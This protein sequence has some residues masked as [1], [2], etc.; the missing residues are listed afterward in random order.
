MRRC[1]DAGE[2]PPARVPARSS[3]VLQT[4]S[5]S[6]VSLTCLTPCGT[7]GQSL[8]RKRGRSGETSR[9]PSGVWR[10][11]TVETSSRSAFSCS[12]GSGQFV[13]GAVGEP[14]G[15]WGLVPS[16]RKTPLVPSSKRASPGA[17]ESDR[18]WVR[19]EAGPGKGAGTT[20]NSMWT[21]LR[22]WA[23]VRVWRPRVAMCLA[24]RSGCPR[25]LGESGCP[26]SLGRPGS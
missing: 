14:R 20:G 15:S 7:Y 22:R 17:P 9:V 10:P 3:S 25:C 6:S 24:A 4:P 26:A 1:S 23:S 13:E 8:G 16:S 18:G 11:R 2:V 19:R 21:T 5:A 12:S